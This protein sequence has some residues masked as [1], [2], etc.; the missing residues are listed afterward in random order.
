MVLSRGVKRSGLHR[1]V[2][3]AGGEVT[4]WTSIPV[5]VQ[6]VRVK[7]DG[8]SDMDIWRQDGEKWL[9]RVGGWGSGGISRIELIGADDRLPV[10]C[11]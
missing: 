7:Y 1:N 5:L 11:V 4:V 6:I 9:G 3:V 2:V 8:D 10:E